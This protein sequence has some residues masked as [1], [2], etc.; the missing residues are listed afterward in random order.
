VFK[1]EA[2]AIGWYYQTRESW[3]GPKALPLQTETG[4]PSRGAENPA[5]RAFAA[6]AWALVLVDR[7]ER[8]TEGG[9]PL[10]AWL[11]AHHAFGLNYERIA[12]RTDYRWST[13]MVK[14]RMARAHRVVRERLTE[15]GW[16]EGEGPA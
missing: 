5:R 14:R 10:A 6:V 1:H 13:D 8:A 15:K 9:A 16:I 7:D 4:R 12:E 3:A 11:E 2:H